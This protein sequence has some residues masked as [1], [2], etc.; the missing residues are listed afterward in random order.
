M[1]GLLCDGD[2]TV[3]YCIRD[4][5]FSAWVQEQCGFI[6]I[7]EYAV[8]VA[9]MEIALGHMKGC[10]CDASHKSS[11]ADRVDAG[12]DSHFLQG[13]AVAESIVSDVSDSLGDVDSG[14]RKATGECIAF[15][16]VYT[17]GDVDFL[18]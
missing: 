14:K 3:W 6:G 2:R 10:E 16:A 17:F 5:L 11:I 8:D 18:K 13:V 1:D 7:E 4:V 12:G 15:D 9:V